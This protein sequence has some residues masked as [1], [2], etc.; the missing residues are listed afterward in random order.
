MI[1]T[2]A[3]FDRALDLIQRTETNMPRVFSGVGRSDIASI[4]STMMTVI[5]TR[6]G[7]VE[8]YKLR[9]L[10][11]NDADA[12]VFDRA[13]RTLTA[14]RFCTLD[15]TNRGMIVRAIKERKEQ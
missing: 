15:H 7:S 8:E 4:M 9:E 12:D 14:M 1:V 10:M 6:G 2:G 5:L 3:D 11:H 13:M